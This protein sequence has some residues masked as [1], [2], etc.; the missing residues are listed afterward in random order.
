MDERQVSLGTATLI[1]FCG[2]GV[3][4]VMCSAWHTF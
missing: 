2:V 3:G 1:W 4:F